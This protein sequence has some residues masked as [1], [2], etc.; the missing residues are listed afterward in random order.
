MTFIEKTELLIN[1]RGAI[2]AMLIEDIGLK[3]GYVPSEMTQFWLDVDNIPAPTCATIWFVS[4]SYAVWDR[5][6]RYWDFVIVPEIPE[7]LR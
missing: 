6:G 5:F 7:A 1:Q 3:V 2:K 4:G